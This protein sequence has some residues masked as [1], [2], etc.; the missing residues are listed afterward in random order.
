MRNQA[1][2]D[3]VVVGVDG[4]HGADFALD[5]AADEARRLSLPVH[6]VHGFSPDL[7]QVDFSP[8]SDVSD[9]EAQAHAVLD[10]AMRRIHLL[11]PDAPVSGVAVRGYVAQAILRAAQ[12]ASMVVMGASGAALSGFTVLGSVSLQVATHAPCPVVVVR[13][14]RASGS[15]H[16]RVVVGYDASDDTAATLAF[17]HR[18]AADHDS[19]LVVVHAWWPEDLAALEQPHRDWEHYQS[20]ASEASRRVLEPMLAARPV[21]VRYEV[22]DA[23]PAKALTAEAAEADLVCVGARGRGG[24]AGLLLGSVAHAVLR[25]AACPVAVVRTRHHR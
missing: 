6:L 18:Y 10:S 4:S 1:G 8:R 2:R 19:E 24:F 9:V 15:R 14:P 23:H 20:S 3:A 25:Y 5:F 16:G 21:P 13:H 22:V 11:A 12:G 7:P 17:A